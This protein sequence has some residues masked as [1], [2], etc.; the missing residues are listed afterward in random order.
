MC[1]L[2]PWKPLAGA[3]TDEMTASLNTDE[4]RLR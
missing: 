3:V 2:M 4:D 1:L